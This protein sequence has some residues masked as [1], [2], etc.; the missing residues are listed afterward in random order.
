MESKGKKIYEQPQT[1]KHSAM[2]LVQGSLYDAKLYYTT[3]Y[4]KLY[5]TTLYYKLYYTT[6][7]YYH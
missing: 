4:Y 5:Y 7:Y 3:L 6:L 1:V 2:N